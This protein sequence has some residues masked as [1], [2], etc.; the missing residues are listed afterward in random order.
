LSLIS[1]GCAGSQGAL[2][3]LIGGVDYDASAQ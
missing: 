2:A 3:L 1:F